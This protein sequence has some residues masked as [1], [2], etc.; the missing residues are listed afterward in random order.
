MEIN[1]TDKIE[2]RDRNEIYD[3]LMNFNVK[4]VKEKPKEL[5][6]FIRDDNQN[7]IAALLG[8]SWG[9]WL[10]INTLWV[11]KEWRRQGV[12]SRIIAIAEDKAAERNCKFVLVDTYD[13]QSPE[14]YKKLDYKDAFTLIECPFSGSRYY[15]IKTL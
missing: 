5:G 2:V 1:I 3:K 14:F 7:T 8:Y 11:E 9:K 12:G 6:V 10:F 15:F 4:E 13:F